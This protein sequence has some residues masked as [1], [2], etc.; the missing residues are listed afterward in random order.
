MPLSDIP[1]IK[2]SRGTIFFAAAFLAVFLF[3]FTRD[4]PEPESSGRADVADS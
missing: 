2:P 3:F 1:A 4:K